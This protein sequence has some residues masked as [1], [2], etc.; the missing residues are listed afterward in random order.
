M[1]LNWFYSLIFLNIS[2]GRGHP[3]CRVRES[4]LSACPNPHW[5]VRQYQ[6]AK[7]YFFRMKIGFE[8]GE[9]GNGHCPDVRTPHWGVPNPP[10]CTWASAVTGPKDAMI[11]RAIENQ[12][13]KV[14]SEP[15][16]HTGRVHLN[17][18]LRY[19]LRPALAPQRPAYLPRKSRWNGYCLFKILDFFKWWA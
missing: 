7:D 8:L 14:L 11:P 5:G 6:G 12:F 13:S 15:R 2:I 19:I 9:L 16:N 10:L 17:L 1:I 18:I 4:A 3:P